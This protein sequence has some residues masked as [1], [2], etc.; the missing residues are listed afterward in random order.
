MSMHKGG[1]L[2]WKSPDGPDHIVIGTPL[3]YNGP[4]QKGMMTA[5][6]DMTNRAVALAEELGPQLDT[7]STQL[8]NH[9]ELGNQEHYA[10]KLLTDYLAGQG[11]EI[12]TPYCGVETGFKATFRGQKPG[13]VICYMAE[14]DAL[15]EIGHGCG[16][17][18]I[19]AISVG[20]GVALARLVGEIGGTAVVLGTPAEE[21]RG[22]KVDYAR[23]GGFDGIDAALIVHPSV[24]NYLSGSTLA[25]APV[26]FEFFGRTA[27]AAGSPEMGIN[28]LDAVI[29]LFNSVNALRQQ[30]LSDS[31]IH[32]VIIKGGEA[33]N[34]IPDYTKAQFYVRSPEKAYN[35]ALRERVINCARGAAQAT[36]CRMEMNEFEYPYDNLRSNQALNA[37]FGQSMEAVGGSPMLPADAREGMG[38]SDVGQV[39][40]VCPTIHPSLDIAD[41]AQMPGHSVAFRDATQTPYAARQLRHSVA[42][43][44]LCGVRMITD[45]ALMADIRR[46]FEAGRA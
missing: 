32:G 19:A 12:E 10:C 41:G 35:D 28:A 26:E 7:L 44:A 3:R 18:M 29:T 23:Q 38:S 37:L 2:E 34:I 43:L 16:H 8:Y 14:Y 27:H 24:G 31:R 25:L 45:P 30:V 46:E 4:I 39:S 1:R 21:T 6:S 9:P 15:P 42:A 33:A 17:N 40:H 20:A 13:P 11:F 5:M 22:A 36:G